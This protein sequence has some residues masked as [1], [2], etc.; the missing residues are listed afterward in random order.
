MVQA[1]ADVVAT[2][3]V[4]GFFA[5]EHSVSWSK[6]GE[7]GLISEFCFQKT[8]APTGKDATRGSGDEARVA[9][10]YARMLQ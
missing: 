3:S 9:S 5:E 7:A 8:H 2:D 1:K 4:E 10:A 6:F